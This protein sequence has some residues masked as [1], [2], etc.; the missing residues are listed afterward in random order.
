M[1][2][3]RSWLPQSAAF[4]SSLAGVQRP[5]AR[6]EGIVSKPGP[7]SPWIRPP[8]WLAAIRKPTPRVLASVTSPCT[9][10]AMARTASTP[11]A[12][13]VV[14]ATDPKWDVVTALRRAWSTRSLRSP[15]MKSCP[16]RCASLSEARVPVTQ[17]SGRGGGWAA[18]VAVGAGGC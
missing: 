10:S 14:N 12:V 13:C 16:I 8:S 1:P 15:T 9:S 11:A 3:L 6:A 18:V 2:A 4:P 7:D 5:W 17:A